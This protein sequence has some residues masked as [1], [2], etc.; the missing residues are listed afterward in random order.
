L[1]GKLIFGNFSTRIEAPSGQVFVA[2]PPAS[3][4][5]LWPFERLIAIDQRI[6]SLGE[7]SDGEV[8]VLT[9][10]QGIPVGQTGKVWKLIRQ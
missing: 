5:D 8:Y 3:W 1:Q 7:D 10:A 2:T 6:H 4:R 9:T